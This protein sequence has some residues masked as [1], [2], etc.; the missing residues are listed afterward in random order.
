VAF[1]Q[2]DVREGLREGVVDDVVDVRVEA[3]DGLDELQQKLLWSRLSTDMS[4][5]EVCEL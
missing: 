1:V 4:G 2:V 3:P 5:S